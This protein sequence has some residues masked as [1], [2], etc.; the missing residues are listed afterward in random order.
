MINIKLSHPQWPLARQTPGSSGVW[1]NCRFFCNT[2]VERCDYWFVLEG[3]EGK[4]ETTLC[5]KGHTVL[6]TCEP[7]TLKTYKTDFLRQFGAIIT[8]HRDIDH[9]NPVFQQSGLPWHVGRR[10][11]NHVNLSFSKDYDELKGMNEIQKT[12]MLSVI[13]SAKL[14]SEGHRKRFEF[15]KLLKE[16]FGDDIDL[17]GR[18]INEIEDKWDA[19]APYRYHVAVENCLVDDYWTEKLADAFLAGCYPIYYGCPNI[20]RYFDP[21]S[22]TTIDINRPEE[23]IAAIESCIKENRYENSRRLIY[24][25]REKVLDRHN[26]F[27]MI[28]EYVESA[29]KQADKQPFVKTTIHKEPSDSN[30]LYRFKRTL[31]NL[32]T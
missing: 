12:K 8:C 28:A 15:A 18:G 27:A 25:S 11:K 22:L 30:L 24:E 17:F 19:L 10:Q 23:A 14:V 3:I 31:L 5:P 29:E 16:Y 21:G 20:S 13:T 2:P 9:P 4:K 32:T 6:I 7:P 1:G 26:L